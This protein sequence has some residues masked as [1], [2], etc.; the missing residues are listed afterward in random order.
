MQAPIVVLNLREEQ[1]FEAAV[2]G[3]SEIDQMA[4][5]LSP[6]HRRI[7]LAQARWEAQQQKKE[8]EQI[9]LPVRFGPS[10]LN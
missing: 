5:A 8:L 10:R 4:R 7:H 2:L 3:Y 9:D 6:G 1:I